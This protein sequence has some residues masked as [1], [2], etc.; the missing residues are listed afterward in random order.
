MSDCRHGIAAEWCASCKTTEPPVLVLEG[1]TI[2]ARHSGKCPGCGDPI[3]EGEDIHL[4]DH[5]W[6]CTSCKAR[7]S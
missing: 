4:T 7:A 6:V 5:G 3:I 1:P 2:A